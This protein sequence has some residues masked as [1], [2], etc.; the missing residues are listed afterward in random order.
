M[1]NFGLGNRIITE[2]FEV[3]LPSGRKTEFTRAKTQY[4][5]YSLNLQKSDFANAPVALAQ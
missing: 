2:N 5:R 4:I 1:T 3:T